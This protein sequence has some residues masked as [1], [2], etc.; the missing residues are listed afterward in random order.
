MLNLKNKT[1]AILIAAILT[2]SMSASLILIPNANAHTPVWNI[3]TYA[4]IVAAPSPIGIGQNAHV[5]MWLN[6]VYGVAGGSTAAVGTNGSTASAALIA[7]SYRFKNYNLTITA[8]DGHATTQIFDTIFDTTSNQFTQFIPDQIGTYTLEFTFP[9][10]TY[11][12][13]GNGYENSV[14]I[15]DTYLPSHAST[16]LTVQQDP[17]A[18]PIN[19][20]PL[21]QQYWSHPIYAENTDW[22][23]ISSDWLGQGSGPVNGYG[24]SANSILYHPDGIGPLTSHVMWTRPLQFGGVVGGDPFIKGGTT[25]GDGGAK[26]AVYY[27]G[28]S[29]QPRFTNPIIVSGYLIYTEPVSF[30]GPRS[31]PTTA[32]DLRTGKILWSRDDVPSLSFAYTFNVW[33]QD[34]HGTFPPILFTSNFGQAFDAYTGDPMFNVINVPSGIA[35]GGPSGEQLRYAIANAGTSTN[36][37]YYLAEWNSSKLWQ[38]DINPYTGGGSTS[39]SVINA[40]NGVLVGS[41]PIPITGASGTTPTGGF[42]SVPYGSSIIIN[43]NIPLN[44]TTVGFGGHGLTTYDWNVSLPI[45]NTMPP[46]YPTINTVTGQLNPVNPNANPVTILA[47]RAGDMLLCRNGSLPSGFSGAPAG[48]SAG[49]GYPQLPYTYF[50]INLNESRGAIGSILWMKTYDPPAGNVTQFQS[51][52]DFDSQVFVLQDWET[53]GYS[54]YSLVDGSLLW[55]TEPQ[56]D[57]N[58]YFDPGQPTLGT[59]AY[60]NFYNAGFGGIV[61]CYDIK[62]GQLKWTYGN[63]GEGNS[64]NGGLQIFYGTYPTELQ[65]IAN[66]VVYIASDEHTIPNPIY[67]GSYLRAINATDGT[68]IWQLSLYPSEWTFSAGLQMAVADGYLTAMNGLDNNVYS[69]GRGPSSTSVEAQAFDTSIVIR[70]RVTDISAGTKQDTQMADFPNGVPVAS[71]ASMKDWMGYVYQQKPFYDNFTGVDVS[72]DV[73]DSNGNYRNIGSATTDRYGMYSLTWTP[74]IPGDF[75]VYAT[76]AGTNGYWPS[77]SETTFTVAEPHPTLAPT[78]APPASN[79]DTYLM[80]SAI[81]IIVV[82]IIGFAALFLALRK[83]P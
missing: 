41:V 48:S 49:L 4:Y 28:S 17:I 29:Y 5:Y 60:G 78:A 69:I 21:P 19:S 15:N 80:I 82:I 73:L 51:A 74:D 9:G 54:G 26:G 23:A 70:G 67:K 12:E 46:P 63:G 75:Q 3:P 37:Q 6:P 14:M 39:P 25:P 33:D 61:Y 40:S 71:D 47:G 58:Y 50:A 1:M 18:D 31:G 8:P 42:A 10:Q 24:G 76:F 22:W 53:I 66:G 79:T 16:T 11:G 52:V 81:A 43:A 68:E 7:N 65:A 35:I 72:I 30:T 2:I 44:S 36:K 55:T 64:T 20:Y 38:Y 57:W 77:T 13:N 34:Q 83:R 62:S 32:I 27:E 59:A 45:V 56:N